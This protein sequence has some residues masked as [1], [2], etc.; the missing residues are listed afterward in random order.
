M[1]DAGVVGQR[2]PLGG[3]VA[4]PVHH[5]RPLLSRRGASVE[6]AWSSRP[7]RAFAAA[8]VAGGAALVGLCLA[9]P[10]LYLVDLPAWTYTGAVVVAEAGGATPWGLY[11]WPVPNTWATLAAAPLV[12]LAGPTGAGRWLAAGLLAAGWAAAWAFAAAVDR[13]TAPA[14][15]AVVASTLVA[16]SSWWNG[17]LGF[18]IGVT[19]ALGLG[20]LVLRRG[21]LPA[22]ALGVGAVALFFA[23]AVPFGAFALGAGLDA[24]RR[25]DLRQVTALVP[26]ALLTAWYVAAR[27]AGPQGGFV[28]PQAAGGAARAVAYKAYTA[29]KLGPFQHPDGLDGAG[30]LAGHPALYWLGVAASGAFMAVLVG[31]LAVGTVRLWRSRAVGRGGAAYGWALV[32]LALALPPFAL[33][34]VNPGERVLVMGAVALLAT[35]SVPRRLLWALG[36][37]ALLFLAD[38]AHALWAQRDGLSAERR[39]ELL[40]PRPAPPERSFEEAVEAAGAEPLPL[41]GHPVLLNARYYGLAE[42]GDWTAPAFDS[43]PLRPPGGRD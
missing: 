22:P 33:N 7:S 2:A 42:R 30:V 8:Y 1:A 35:V 41:L 13:E 31:A 38:D 32:A 36:G 15:A 25:R 21:R 4:R 24:L 19:L 9:A 5:P 20:A 12:A 37:A 18:Q 29:L 26:A 43:G 39:A 17:Y 27:A 16:S 14:R 34:V 10:Q 28:A 40:S 23:H 6:S 3:A 11:P